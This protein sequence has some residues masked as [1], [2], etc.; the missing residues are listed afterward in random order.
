MR[1]EVAVG[2]GSVVV[3]YYHKVGIFAQFVGR[4][5][6]RHSLHLSA[7]YA[8]EGA[9]VGIHTAVQGHAKAIVS[10]HRALQ[11]DVIAVD[12]HVASNDVDACPPQSVGR[13]CPL[14]RL[15]P[16][17]QLRHSH[18]DD[19]SRG[20]GGSVAPSED[21]HIDRRVAIRCEQHPHAMPF[22]V[23]NRNLRIAARACVRLVRCQRA[24]RVVHLAYSAAEHL[25]SEHRRA[26]RVHRCG[27]E[28]SAQA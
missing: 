17:L 19:R 7:H 28:V 1:N 23:A 10:R 12:H 14:C 24:A 11:V 13:R 21:A 3:I 27:A 18:V 22:R 8:G 16:D 9:V 6:R 5:G 4:V 25:Q 20:R 26:R 15:A 2:A